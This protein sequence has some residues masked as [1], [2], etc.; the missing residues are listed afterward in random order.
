MRSFL[1]CASLA[2]LPVA[3][4]AQVVTQQP[5]TA[6]GVGAA[7]VTASSASL[8]SLITMNAL[9][10]AQ[11]PTSGFAPPHIWVRNLGSTDVAFCPWGGTCSCPETATSNTVG[12]TIQAGGGA[13][14]YSLFLGN[15]LVPYNTPTIVSCSGTNQVEVDIQ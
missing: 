5:P 10:P 12:Y 7:T 2:L 15:T 3:G 13:Y 1:L 6:Q 4:R 8:A 14:G 11:W 9:S